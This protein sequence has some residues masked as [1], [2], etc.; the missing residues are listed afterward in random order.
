MDIKIIIAVRRKQ[1]TQ[2]K[3]WKA[4]TFQVPGKSTWE[5]ARA[6]SPIAG[7]VLQGHCRYKMDPCESSIL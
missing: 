4:G 5:G 7:G 1:C 2:L 3:P 6:V